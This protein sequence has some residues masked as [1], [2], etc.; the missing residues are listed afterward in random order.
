M[1]G[2]HYAEIQSKQSI[3]REP[4]L[5]PDRPGEPCRGVRHSP[6]YCGMQN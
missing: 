5:N 6:R 2:A 4:G 1:E 3:E